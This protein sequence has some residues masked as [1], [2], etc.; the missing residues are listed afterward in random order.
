MKLMGRVLTAGQIIKDMKD[1]GSR[2]KCMDKVFFIGQMERNMMAILSM[3]KGKD[4]EFSPGKTDVFMKVTGKMANKMG[5]ANLL[6]KM[7]SKKKENGQM[8]KR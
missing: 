7:E 4:M 5:E 8:V 3:I 1:S 6:V 2:T